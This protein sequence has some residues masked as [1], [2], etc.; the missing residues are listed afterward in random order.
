[1]IL[2]TAYYPEHWPKQR[3]KTDAELMQQAGMS[4]RRLYGIL[5]NL[6]IA[7][8]KLPYIIF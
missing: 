4:W 6:R 5:K 7:N 1:M 8:R 3:W 2:A